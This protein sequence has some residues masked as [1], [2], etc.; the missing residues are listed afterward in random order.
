MSN[1]RALHSVGDS[2]ATWLSNAYPSDMQTDFPCTFTLASSAAMGDGKFQDATLTLFLYRVTMN[3]HL[4]SARRSADPMEL[5]IPLSIDL[6]YLLTVWTDDVAREHT[7]LAWTMLQLQQHPVFDASSL[8]PTAGWSVGEH[9][10]VLPE[11]LPPDEIMRLW[12]SLDPSYRLSVSYTARVV[13]IEGDSVRG[14]PVVE[15]ELLLGGGD[16]VARELALRAGA[17]WP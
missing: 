1:V 10:Q 7:I 3:Q 2:L 4:R 16:D 12:D 13:R 9:V 17:P 15:R 11:E 6:H 14:R 5:S 8:A